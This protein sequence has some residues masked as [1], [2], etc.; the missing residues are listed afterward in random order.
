M[1]ALILAG[2]KGTRLRPY[3]TVI[4]KPLMPVGEL[5]IL[6]I[7]LRQ[8][9]YYEID[10]VILAVGYMSQLFQAFFN[11]GKR[12]GLTITYSFEN[13]PLGT[14]GPIA[15]VIQ[16]LSETFI[17]LN[18]DLLTT[19]NY[20]NMIDF[21]LKE[22]AS[23]TI[24]L[25]QRE[26]RIDFG[27]V[28]KDSNN[29]LIKYIEKPIN[30]INVSMGVNVFNRDSVTKYL[31]PGIYLDIPDLM[32]NMHMDG[33]PVKCYSE[34]CYWLDIGRVE[35]YQIANEIFESRRKEFLKEP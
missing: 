4:P 9:K 13:K 25:Y 24:G 34:E 19:L 12:Y 28:E 7:L 17:V 35:D 1:K 22:N 5:P 3:T 33:L 32:T 11:N 31:K 10:E 30:R 16:E 20:Q 2:G 8:L 27:V 14:A 15:N 29:K 18:G 23:A 6:E 21:H 26:V